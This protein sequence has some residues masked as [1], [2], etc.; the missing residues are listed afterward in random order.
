MCPSPACRP[1]ASSELR[2]LTQGDPIAAAAAAAAATGDAAHA[3]HGTQQ[4]AFGSIAKL[5]PVR[6]SKKV[7]GNLGADAGQVSLGKDTFVCPALIFQVARN[8]GWSFNT[9]NWLRALRPAST[10]AI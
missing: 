7:A 4:P 3:A 5:S 8:R 1:H 10:T 9:Q 6:A 2:A